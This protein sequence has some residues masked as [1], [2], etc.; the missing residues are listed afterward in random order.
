MVSLLR[1]KPPVPTP[2]AEDSAAAVDAAAAVVSAAAVKATSG[3]LLPF[4][5]MGAAA[6]RRWWAVTGA[7]ATVVVLAAISVAVFGVG[8]VGGYL[9]TL[10]AQQQLVSGHSVPNDAFRVFGREGLPKALK[11][12]FSLLFLGVLGLLLHRA[13]KGADWI[14]SAGWATLALLLSM[15][16]LMPW[17]LVWLLPLAALGRSARL[18]GATLAL[19]GFMVMSRG[20][21][22]LT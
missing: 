8:G 4:L 6:S 15:T 9:E 17:Y 20:I 11:P 14:A 18:R 3:L 5:V 13:L 12:L 7:V 16:F 1:K 19:M 21:V 2:P 22:L 10:Y